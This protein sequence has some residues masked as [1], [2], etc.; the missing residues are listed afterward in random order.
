MSEKDNPDLSEWLHA[1]VTDQAE[2]T[3]E[4][5]L[6]EGE[7]APSCYPHHFALNGKTRT[8]V[9]RK[10]ACEFLAFDA[11]DYVARDW[12]NYVSNL[13]ALRSDVDRLTEKRELLRKQVQSL[14]AMDK[15]LR[16][17][18]DLVAGH[19][20]DWLEGVIAKRV[21]AEYREVVGYIARTVRGGDWRGR[22]P[23]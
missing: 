21:K 4:S 22:P 9:C 14:K 8:V 10:C 11:L 1:V 19:I 2:T 17:D 18:G 16:A 7:R 3:T 12:K 20:A 6:V 13:Q 15:R 5:L 23:E